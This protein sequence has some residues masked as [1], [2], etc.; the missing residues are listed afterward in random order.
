M[1][2]YEEKLIHPHD[3]KGD[4]Y[5]LPCSYLLVCDGDCIGYA[6]SESHLEPHPDAPPQLRLFSCWP[7]LPLLSCPI[8][9]LGPSCSS[10]FAMSHATPLSPRRKS[11]GHLCACMM[12]WEQVFNASLALL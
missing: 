5:A 11:K 12:F 6:A 3:S 8:V 10:R 2:A 4:L 1:R 9:K 7:F